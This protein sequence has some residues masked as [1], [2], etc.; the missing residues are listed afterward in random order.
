[1]EE[2]KTYGTLTQAQLENMLAEIQVEDNELEER[3]EQED[4]SSKI[5]DDDIVNLLKLISEES[6]SLTEDEKRED[7]AWLSRYNLKFENDK[8]IG[9]EPTIISRED[10]ARRIHDSYLKAKNRKMQI[11][12]YA[13]DQK[14]ITLSDCIPEENKCKLLQKIDEKNTHSCN[15]LLAYISKRISRLL[16]PFIPI[17]LR[18]CMNK[19]PGMVASHPGFLYKCTEEYG[20]SLAVWVIPSIPAYFEPNSEMSLLNELPRELLFSIDKAVVKYAKKR[21]IAAQRRLSAAAN[22]AKIRNM[23]YIRVLKHNPFWFEY[24]YE[25]LTD[26]KIPNYE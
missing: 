22:I 17:D 15:V 12:R 19:Y 7:G 24:L 14:D 9:T 13:F 21:A 23:T 6:E 4:A 8:C 3:I 20:K 2:I 18:K 26:K 16:A 1:M 10:N 11:I 5:C 25:I